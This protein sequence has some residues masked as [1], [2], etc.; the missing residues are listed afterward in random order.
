MADSVNNT[1]MPLPKQLSTCLYVLL[2]FFLNAG[3]R[4]VARAA[5]HTRLTFTSAGWPDLPALL[6]KTRAQAAA[7]DCSIPAWRSVEETAAYLRFHPQPPAARWCSVRPRRRERS[8]LTPQPADPEAR[9]AASARLD[10]LEQHMRAEA[11]RLSRQALS[12]SDVGV[13]RNVVL[14]ADKLMLNPRVVKTA[15]PS[16]CRIRGADGEE[17]RVPFYADIVVEYDTPS[18]AVYSA[19]VR[20][21]AACAAQQMF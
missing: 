14:L 21:L 2:L 6:A 15:N 1:N 11:A 10:M 17:R 20:E 16:V 7:A 4:E 12:A 3:A 18:G 9:R 5:A 19:A 13:P 8:A